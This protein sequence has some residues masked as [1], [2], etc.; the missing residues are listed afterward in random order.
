L[1]GTLTSSPRREIDRTELYVVEEM[2]LYGTGYQVLPIIAVDRLNV[3]DGKTG[4]LTTA[5][6]EKY[7]AIACGDIP[8]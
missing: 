5:M 7:T 1:P 6:N 4:P 8:D 3:G 2:F